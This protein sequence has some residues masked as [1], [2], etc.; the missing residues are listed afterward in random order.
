M[1][2]QE[3]REL[4]GKLEGAGAEGDE[5][6]AVEESLKVVRARKRALPSL[7]DESGKVVTGEE[8]PAYGE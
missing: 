2:E 4:V 7:R 3:E 5:R 1:L 6:I 8:L